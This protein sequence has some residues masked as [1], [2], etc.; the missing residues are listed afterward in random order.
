LYFVATSVEGECSLTNEVTL[1]PLRICRQIPWRLLHSVK[2]FVTHSVLATLGRLSTGECR[3]LGP[4]QTGATLWLS[5]G[6]FERG[7]I[8]CQWVHITLSGTQQRR[9]GFA[10]NAFAHPTISQR[11]TQK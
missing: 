7:T 4:A 5:S 9:S 1:E 2:T 6:V 10:L 11:Q 8:P 3:P